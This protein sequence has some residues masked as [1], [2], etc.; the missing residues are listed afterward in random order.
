M[1]VVKFGVVKDPFVPDPAIGVVVVLSAYHLK[2][3]PLFPVA[4]SVADCPTQTVLPLQVGGLGVEIETVICF[5]EVQPPLSVT[6]SVNVSAVDV[7]AVAVPEDVDTPVYAVF[8][9][10]VVGDQ[11]IV[12]IKFGVSD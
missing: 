12:C 11:A 6:V 7:L 5:F 4:L 2:V 8:D 1:A 9:K 3:A 10:L